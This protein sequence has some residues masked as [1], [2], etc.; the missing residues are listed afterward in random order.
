M[1]LRWLSQLHK[2]ENSPEIVDQDI[3][4]TLSFYFNPYE[5][6]RS[7]LFKAEARQA[8][9]NKAS[10]LVYISKFVINNY[11][12]LASFPD[13]VASKTQFHLRQIGI[14]QLS[15]RYISLEELQ[16]LL[17]EEFGA[18]WIKALFNFCQQWTRPQI[19]LHEWIVNAPN[20]LETWCLFYNY[21]CFSNLP[22]CGRLT[23]FHIEV[24][25]ENILWECCS[26]TMQ[27]NSYENPDVINHLN[28]MKTF[29]PP[30]DIKQL[31]EASTLIEWA[32]K[33]LS[34]K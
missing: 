25:K 29:L 2:L 11:P 18:S 3:Y 13:L 6:L 7:P 20:I 22:E 21:L 26:L 31:Q 4:T 15:K 9:Q 1:R 5:K 23:N 33:K 10:R 8:V 30:S 19:P 24:L 28:R 17:I 32:I 14:E 34:S 27:T 16:M 12:D